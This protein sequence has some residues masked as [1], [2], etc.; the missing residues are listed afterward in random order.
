[1]RRD[2]GNTPT[3]KQLSEWFSS[4]RMARYANAPDPASLY[5]WD[6]RLQKA[7]LEDIE[8]VEVLLRNFI[9]SRLANDCARITGDRH[10]YDH[11]DVYN[12]NDRFL[13]SIEKARKRLAREGTEADYDH[14]VASLSLD[15]WRF[16]LTRRLEP[17]VWRALRDKR[18]GGMPHYP[19]KSRS[20][21][22]ANVVS[23]YRLRNRCSHQEHLVLDDLTEETNVLDRYEASVQWVARQ[24]NPQ[25]HEWIASISR[26]DAVRNERP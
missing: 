24:I 2:M 25:A 7:F 23:L 5:A 18:N 1:M 6:V 20:D 17:T 15:T 11:A 12:L 14:L 21:F 4:P 16:L 19:S 13:S 8:H 26:V 3:I 9:A 22:E 10:W